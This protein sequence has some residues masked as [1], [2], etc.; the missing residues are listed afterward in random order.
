M[1]SA[2]KLETMQ[3]FSEFSPEVRMAFAVGRAYGELE[4]KAAAEADADEQEQE[5]DEE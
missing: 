3:M 4:R 5:A 1:T 2:E